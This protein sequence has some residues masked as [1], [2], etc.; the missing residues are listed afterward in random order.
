MPR[1]EVSESDVAALRPLKLASEFCEMH[2][3]AEG[4][5]SGSGVPLLPK[6]AVDPIENVAADAVAISL[7]ETGNSV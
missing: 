2:L 6:E 3:A 4:F 5:V 7:F 1:K